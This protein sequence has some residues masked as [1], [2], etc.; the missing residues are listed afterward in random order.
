MNT[1]RNR[2]IGFFLFLP[3]FVISACGVR[4]YDVV[5]PRLETYQAERISQTPSPLP[6]SATVFVR[7]PSATLTP[8]PTRTHSPT[9]TQTQVATPCATSEAITFM[10]LVNHA[11][12][13]IYVTLVDAC[14]NEYGF[15][16]AA[17]FTRKV[18]FPAGE[19]TYRILIPGSQEVTG[20]KG[21]DLGSS[22][23]D[24]YETNT[25]LDS[26]TPLFTGVP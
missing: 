26:P 25:I 14:G 13:T 2:I 9:R 23:W 19:Y 22:T 11:P 1:R 16:M 10:T 21:F 24:F 8:S 20:S 17:A 18:Q 6:G 7:T 3:L 4:V 12:Y 5:M 15:P